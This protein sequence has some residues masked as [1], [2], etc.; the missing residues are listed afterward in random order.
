MYMNENERRAMAL[1]DRY[2]II[3]RGHFK[4]KE[5]H[6]DIFIH[7]ERVVSIAAV[8]D[9]FCE[10]IA[11]KNLE[12]RGA[13]FDTSVDV[14]LGIGHRG[15]ILA[16]QV[17]NRLQTWTGRRVIAVAAIKQ[18]GSVRLSPSDVG[19][20]VGRNVLTV[21]DIVRTGGT[22][23]EAMRLITSSRGNNC[24]LSAFF[25]RGKLADGDGHG[26]R[27]FVLCN[28][29]FAL[30]THDCPKCRQGIPLDPTPIEQPAFDW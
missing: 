13:S 14:V 20:L 21:A 19:L 28:P 7:L 2:N 15:L 29:D 24:G 26:R 11:R 9:V 12:P 18:D 22:A 30:W 5:Y 1:C 3:S 6:S 27:P 10:A 8:R 17:A 25:R 4:I 23:E 16:D